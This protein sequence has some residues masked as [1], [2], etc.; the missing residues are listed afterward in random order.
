MLDTKFEQLLHQHLKYLPP[1]E[2]VD[3][4]RMLEDYGFDSLAAV[5]LLLEIEDTYDIVMPDKYLVG[6]TFS[7]A[8]TLWE[9]VEQLQRE[10]AI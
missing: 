9:V 10:A 2:P 7:T 3:E 1:S 8:R 6:N 4:D 5:S